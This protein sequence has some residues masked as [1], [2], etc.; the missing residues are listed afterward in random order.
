[1]FQ[2][3]TA[4]GA[5]GAF[6][7]GG[8]SRFAQRFHHDRTT[9]IDREETHRVW[10]LMPR[11]CSLVHR[12]TRSSGGVVRDETAAMRSPV[13]IELLNGLSKEDLEA[14]ELFFRTRRQTGGTASDA[15]DG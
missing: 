10:K 14:L 4:S 11:F 7:E 12:F 3:S 6:W 2:F 13:E 15:R 8:L 1:M 9:G 5:D